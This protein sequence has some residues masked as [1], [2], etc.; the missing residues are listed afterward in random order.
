M[1]NLH[2]LLKP[3]ADYLGE[4]KTILY[5][6]END[7]TNNNDSDI[8]QTMEQTMEQKE[9]LVRSEERRVGKECA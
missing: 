4:L 9:G 7:I 1:S 8:E 3:L 5:G 2:R 6:L